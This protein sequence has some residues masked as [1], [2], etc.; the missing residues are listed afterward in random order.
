M[1]QTDDQLEH[2]LEAVIQQSCKKAIKAH[3]ALSLDAMLHLIDQLK[4]LK[5]PYTCP[6][7]RPIMIEISKQELE[8]KF[9]RT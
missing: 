6:H 8:K 1:N 2:G 4:Q 7:G 3:D 9:K 5:D